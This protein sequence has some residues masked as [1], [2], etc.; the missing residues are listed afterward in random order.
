MEGVSRE[1]KL[2]F[3]FRGPVG[4]DEFE[5]TIFVGAVDFVADDRVS[6]MCE[7]DADLMSAPGF[8]FGFDQRKW[9]ALACESFENTA[10]RERWVSIGMNSLF[11]PDF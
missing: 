5:V 6:S 7:V 4:C 11:E 1:K 9:S 3:Q 2:G 10:G 8:W